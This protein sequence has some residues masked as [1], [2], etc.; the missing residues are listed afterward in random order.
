MDGAQREG[1]REGVADVFADGVQ[2]SALQ[3]GQTSE[4]QLCSFPP[5]VLQALAI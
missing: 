1:G 5:R 2:F 4:A 3:S